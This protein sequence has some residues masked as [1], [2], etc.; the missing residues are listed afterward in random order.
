MRCTVT[1]ADQSSN[2]PTLELLPHQRDFVDTVF[3]PKSSR[4]VHLRSAAGLGKGTALVAAT[5]RQLD[6][7]PHSHVLFI[8][9]APLRSQFAERLREVA[10]PAT[11]I[12]RYVFREMLDAQSGGELWPLG[13]VAILSSEFAK[14]DD[15]LESL[16]QVDWD[17]LVVDES[18]RIRVA[19]L[20]RI[21]ARCKK[22]IFVSTLGS[23]DSESISGE[24]TIV[25]W[26]PQQIVGF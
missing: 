19:L 10:V 22:A 18:H 14:Q 11:V 16:L 23:E 21:A 1:S 20:R 3:S 17:L 8:V 2:R 9:P 4:I 6:E 25:E 5:K 12:D 7:Q 24:S 15:V 26:R 13:V